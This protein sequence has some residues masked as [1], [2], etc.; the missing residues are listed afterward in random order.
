[1]RFVLKR[2][3]YYI[4]AF[5]AALTLNF[6]LPRTMPGDPATTLFANF[7]GTMR[8][9]QLRALKNAYGLNGAPLPAQ[10]VTYLG[11]VLH[12]NLGISL[13]QFPSPVSEVIANGLRWTLL[14]GLTSVILSFAIG[15]GIGAI[16]GWLRGGLADSIVPPLILL[17]G[18][19]PAFFF[20][21]I[22]V[23]FAA[24]ILGWFPQ[25]HAYGDT[26]I[27]GFSV[28][29]VLSVADH[30]ILP[31]GTI[32]AV[33]LAGWL[34]R[35]RNTMI[36]VLAEDYLTVAEA[37][38]LS[39]IRILTWYAARNAMLPNITAFGMALGFIVSGQLLTEIVFSYPGLGYQLLQAVE[40]LDYP[41]MQALF[42]MITAT[43][44]VANLF[45]DILYARLD[46]RAAGE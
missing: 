7:K 10:Y 4:I 29:Y 38:G 18:S 42:L 6:V 27:P 39:R 33:S 37:K 34:I 35:M 1:M 45:V 2:L 13:S 11:N 43:V 5:W 28:T 36:G 12:G 24:V 8:P 22:T 25:S 23:Y 31:A 46:P 20:A 15:S 3:A 17:V 14:L 40:S 9:D 41:L 21:L 16:V 30:L 44:L 26:V 19:F 32:V